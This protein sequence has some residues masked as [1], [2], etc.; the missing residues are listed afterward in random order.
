M[1]YN[2]NKKF[3]LLIIERLDLQEQMISDLSSVIVK[4]IYSIQSSVSNNHKSI[5]ETM[6]K[7][8]EFSNESRSKE[9]ES[10]LKSADDLKTQIMELGEAIHE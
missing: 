8:S 9:V 4:Q 6:A 7:Y 1:T 3:E 5:T 10:I 2:N